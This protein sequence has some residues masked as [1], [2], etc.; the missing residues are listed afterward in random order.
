MHRMEDG[1][2]PRSLP[3]TCLSQHESACASQMATAAS[4]LGVGTGGPAVWT[5]FLTVHVPWDQTGF[6]RQVQVENGRKGGGIEENGGLR[7]RGKQGGK[8]GVEA[9]GV[10]AVGA[11]WYMRGHGGLRK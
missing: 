4:G 3:A 7:G 8:G 2:M 5:G 10:L 9:A 6:S 11:G 1:L